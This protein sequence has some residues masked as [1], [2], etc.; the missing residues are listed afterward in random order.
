VGILNAA[1]LLIF[2][3]VALGNLFLITQP[4]RVDANYPAAAVKWIQTHHPAGRLFNSYNW[5]GYLLWTL[6]EYPVFIDGRAD[7]YG[8]D[9]IRQ[10]HDVVNAGDNALSILDSWQVNVVLVEPY[11]DIVD[12]L[13]DQGWSVVFEDE[14]AV[15][16]LRG[17][18]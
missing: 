6:P 15:L 1:I 12:V 3:A 9:L 13:K 5:G 11:W 7:L 2:A 10:W 16:F 4:E 18:P 17:K 14:K 8:N